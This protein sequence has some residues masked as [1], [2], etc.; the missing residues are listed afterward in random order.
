MAA[1]EQA[2]QT[3]VEFMRVNQEWAIPIVFLVAFCECVA[4]LS[5]LVRYGRMRTKKCSSSMLL[6]ARST[7]RSW[8]NAAEASSTISSYLSRLLTSSSGRPG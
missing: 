7:G 3:L 6:T 1:L 8:L 2:M 5:W 4:I